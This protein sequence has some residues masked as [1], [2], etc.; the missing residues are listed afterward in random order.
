MIISFAKT[1]GAL[2]AKR[3]RR[4]RREW[5]DAHA[6]S[7]TKAFREGKTFDAWNYSPRVKSRDPHKVE[8]IRL[9]QAPFRQMSNEYEP[10]EDFEAEGFG[11]MCENGMRAEVEAIEIDWCSRP[12]PLYVVDF[13]VV[14]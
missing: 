11:W 6:A 14:G 5:S 9:T 3:K 8:T 7:V 10:G 2:Q 4:T 12:R 1:T 13:E